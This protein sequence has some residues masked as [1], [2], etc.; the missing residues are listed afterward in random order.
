NQVRQILD[1]VAEDGNFPAALKAAKNLTDLVI[2]NAR[3]TDLDSFREAAYAER[4]LVFVMM[5]PQPSQKAELQY[6]RA[7]DDFTRA[8][9]FLR[10]RAQWRPQAYDVLKAL[11]DK[12]GDKIE[13]YPNLAAAICV[14]HSKPFKLRINESVVNSTNPVELFEYYVRNESR[15]FFGI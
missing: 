13:K 8:L 2:A 7:N 10:Q 1:R 14:V 11:R 4:I 6:L 5:I 3:E 15:M 12:V 9:L